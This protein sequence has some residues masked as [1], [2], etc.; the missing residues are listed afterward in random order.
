AA[1]LWLAG[2]F[3]L[4][5]YTARG[6]MRVRTLRRC[7]TLAPA[8]HATLAGLGRHLGVTRPVPLYLSV[9]VDVPAVIGYLRPYI[10]LPISAVTGLDESQIAAVLAHELA[11]VRRHDYLVNMLQ[12]AVETVLFFHPAVWWISRRIREE[13]ELCCDD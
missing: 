4:S 7:A 8:M 9:A 1:A 5:M 6:W 11:H 13:R 3:A 10:L 2:V 12:S